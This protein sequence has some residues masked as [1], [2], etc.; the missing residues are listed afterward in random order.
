MAISATNLIGNVLVIA[1]VWIIAP[2][3]MSLLNKYLAKNFPRKNSYVDSVLSKVNNN[4]SLK[5]SFKK[6]YNYY[7]FLFMTIWLVFAMFLYL[8]LFGVYEA[9]YGQNTWVTILLPI[10]IIS[11]LGPISQFCDLLMSRISKYANPRLD[12][13]TF[14]IYSAYYMPDGTQVMSRKVDSLK[15]HKKYM[16]I[17]MRIFIATLI[18]ALYFALF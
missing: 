3:L 1:S 13:D 14:F 15:F 9:K 12:W 6:F 8:Y 18:L 11:S 17:S 4:P 10:L 5:K 16:D 7:I 2:F